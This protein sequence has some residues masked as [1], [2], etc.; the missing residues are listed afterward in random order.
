MNFGKETYFW[1]VTRFRR[2]RFIERAQVQ[3]YTLDDLVGT[4]GGYI[5]MFIGYA[6]VQFSQFL[7]FIFRSVRQQFLE[8]LAQNS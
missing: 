6:L 3:E 8:R 2:T 4:C 7:Q 5:G 1:I